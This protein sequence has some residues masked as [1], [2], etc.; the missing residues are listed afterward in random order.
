M[1]LLF[2]IELWHSLQVSGYD[3]IGLGREPMSAVDL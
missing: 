3:G 2:R 1:V